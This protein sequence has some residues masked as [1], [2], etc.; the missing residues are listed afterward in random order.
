MNLR[1]IEYA[2]A[3]AEEGSFT[4]AAHRCHTVQSALSHQIARLEEELDARLFERTSRSV[5]LTRAGEAFL[6]A[7]RRALDATGRIAA[8]VAAA[9][10]EIRG[11]LSVGTISTL[12]AIDL[13]DVLA[14]FHARHPQVDIR[15]NVGMSEALL[16]NVRE[17]RA[18]FGFIGLWP[19]ARLPAVQ[20]RLLAEEKLMALLPP[21]HPH[22]GRRSIA[23]AELARF[24]LV[25]FYAGSSARRQTD[26]AFGA[27]RIE[28]RVNFEVDHIDLLRQ[29]VRKGLALGL[30]PSSLAA[31]AGGL[32]S[33]PIT[34]APRRRVYAIWSSTPSPAA[35]AFLALLESH[36]PS[37]TDT[38]HARTR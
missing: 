4:R 36:F 10:G 37:H 17:G 7:A 16:D 6:A 24:P 8:E 19:S 22:V 13:V 30:V 34:D 33:V 2:I 3:V 26:E 21:R 35:A 11:T 15:L 5:R 27:A 28:R 25:D 14:K 9:Q 29:I 23:L 31:Q 1:Q 20:S 18:D 32:P 38:D 12:T